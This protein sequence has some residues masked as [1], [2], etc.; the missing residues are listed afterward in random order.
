MPGDVNG[1]ARF[2]A[3]PAK[4]RVSVRRYGQRWLATVRAAKQPAVEWSRQ[5]RHPVIAVILALR[6]AER[7]GV[8]GVDLDMSCSYFHPMRRKRYC[9]VCSE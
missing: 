1:L 2:R 8:K 5:A 6:A 7:G 9:K 4:V 3:D